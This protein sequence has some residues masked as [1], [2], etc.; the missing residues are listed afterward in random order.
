MR[1]TFKNKTFKIMQI[2]DVQDGAKVSPDT[3]NLIQ[4]ALDKEKPDLV[5]Y[6]GDQ[7]WGYT[8]FRGNKEKIESALRA[9]TAPVTQ[10]N[11][12][13]TICF[14]N[15]DRQVGVS[16]KEQFEIYKKMD[17]F[18]GEDTD[19]IDGC[20]NHV[21]EICEEEEIKY[22]LYL[23][24]SNTSLSGGRYDNVH[25]NQIEWYKT[26]RDKYEAE[27]GGVIPSVVIQH[28][29]VPEVF[30]LINE[31]KK[32]TKGAV[33]GFRNHAG[34]WYVLNKD[35]VN[36]EGFMKESPADP[37]ENSGEFEAMTEKGDVKG[38]YFGHDHINSFNGK[39]NGVDLGYTQG[40]GFHVYGP[41]LDRGVRMINLHK[42]GS[43]D[44][45]DLRYRNLIGTK[46][47]E[48]L[49]FAIFQI[50]PTNVYDAVHRAIKVL[51]GLIGIA[52]AVA[53]IVFLTK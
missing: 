9:I 31:V 50:M 15:H 12:P 19:G 13:F 21:L 27:N 10:R 5:V 24:D 2:A 53:I 45:Y 38:I 4:A 41:G 7:I 6:S 20:A 33:Q 25:E 17:G 23:I 36:S 34:K 29:P 18:V 42:D 37:M 46:V 28:I 32:G 49:R 51:A 39:V 30:E 8:N 43:L 47:Q 35:K 52:A 22:L 26:T 14:G 1:L 11:I 48:K 3:I 44:T 40:A 16:N